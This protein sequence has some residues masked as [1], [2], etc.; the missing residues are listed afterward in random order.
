MIS[1]F[2]FFAIL[3][4]QLARPGQG[5]EKA[6]RAGRGEIAVI[7]GFI[8]AILLLAGL[9]T[10][11]AISGLN[12]GARL[13][14]G[15]LTK[16]AHSSLPFVERLLFL[17]FSRG[18][19]RPEP[20]SSSRRGGIWDLHQGGGQSWWMEWVDKILG[21][22]LWGVFALLSAAMGA[23]AVIFLAKWLFSR[24]SSDRALRGRPYGVVRWLIRMWGKMKLLC[25]T[26]KRMTR[27]RRRA[28]DAYG[29]LLQWARRTGCPLLRGETPRE[30]GTR[31]GSRFTVLG[32]AIGTIVQFYNQEVYGGEEPARERFKSL[33]AA[34][35]TLRSPLYWPLRLKARVLGGRSR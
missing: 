10:A 26:L 14:H 35:R 18:N 5:G 9:A 30:F 33:A 4:I 24:T 27:S 6:P 8:L 21:Y 12:S 1:P 13:A 31:L 23:L 17:L 32:P 3:A 34:R 7:T 20:A 29:T 22:G 25:G 19:V 28:R 16:A 2:F 15:A 11:S